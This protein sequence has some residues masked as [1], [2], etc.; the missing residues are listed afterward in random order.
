MIGIDILYYCLINDYTNLSVNDFLSM[1][2]CNTF[3]E[4]KENADFN[5]NLT[6]CS[7]LELNKKIVCPENWRDFIF[8]DPD[9]SLLVI[10]LL[11]FVS[12]AVSL[13]LNSANLSVNGESPFGLCTHVRSTVSTYVSTTNQKQ[14]NIKLTHLITPMQ[15]LSK[16]KNFRKFL[17]EFK[18]VL[19]EIILLPRRKKLEGPLKKQKGLKIYYTYRLTLKKEGQNTNQYYMGYRSCST[20]PNLDKYYS[21]SKQVHNWI[22]QNGLNCVTKKILGVYITQKEALYNEVRYNTKLKIN[23]NN[24]FLNQARQTSTAFVYDNTGRT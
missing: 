20:S 8:I 24:A 7:K 22:K 23:T 12:L 6:G 21:S 13:K 4:K 17:S 1:S 18:Q 14:E 19:T 2:M 15:V 10:K 5:L 9:L 3:Y 11:M 16:N